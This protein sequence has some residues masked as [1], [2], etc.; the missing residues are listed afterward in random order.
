MAAPE[1]WLVFQLTWLLVSMIMIDLISAGKLRGSDRHEQN[2]YVKLVILQSSH[3][4]KI[5]IVAV[6]ACLPPVSC[7]VK[8][9]GHN[10][11]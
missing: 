7:N 8:S 4:E 11:L 9:L 6:I 1:D 3:R 2:V 5:F 10:D